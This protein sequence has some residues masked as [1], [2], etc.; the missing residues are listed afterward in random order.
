MAAP[1]INARRPLE[2]V[3]VLDM[4][5]L[6]PGPFATLCL[7]DL[8]ASVD[9]LEDPAPGDY[10]RHFPPMRGDQGAVFECINRDKRSVVLDLKHPDGPATL[11]R[12][13]RAYD[14][15]VEGFRPGVLDRLGVGHESLLAANPRLIVCAITGFGQDGP[16]AKRAGHDIGYLARAGVLG[17][18]GPADG[19]PAV[20]G[21][22]MADIAGGALWAVSG[23][24]AALLDRARTGEGCVVDVAMCEGALPLATFALGSVFAGEPSPARGVNTLDG[25][26]APYNTYRTRD[27]RA[28]ALGALEPKFWT[29]FAGAVDVDP[30]LDALVPG[31]HQVA[32]KAKLVEVFA[33]R[34]R[35]EWEDFSRAHD[36]CLEPVL[37][38]DELRSDPHLRARGVFFDAPAR[39]GATVTHLR[40][41][42]G[43]G[44]SVAHTPAARA[45]A[46]T[47]AVLRDAGF[48][49]DEARALRDKG[50]VSG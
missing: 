6:L 2:G 47:D 27:G 40:T 23:V 11:L 7:A 45:G 32:L 46:D 3:R 50:V 35:D 26:I 5:R 9:K 18:T 21:A 29:T 14:V 20:S 28:V 49:D 34:T 43:A 13:A 4:T 38:P 8:G 30:S 33:A 22:Q 17:V 36:C 48:T 16:L 41:P 19:A 1:R 44:A 12:L 15:I 42:L 39:D 10:L 24:L 37:E 31:P 25:G